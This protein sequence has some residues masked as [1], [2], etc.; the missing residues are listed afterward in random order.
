MWET[1]YQMEQMLISGID[2]S[3]VITHRFHIDDFQQGFDVMDSG[4]C[5]K[6]ILNWD[7]MLKTILLHQIP[8]DFITALTLASANWSAC[9]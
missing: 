4:V 5:G 7:W 8:K 1:W 9:W 6:V 2:L 3:P